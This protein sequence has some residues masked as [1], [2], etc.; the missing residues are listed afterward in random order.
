MAD[1]R[2]QPY[3][4]DPSGDLEKDLPQIITNIDETFEQ[5]INDLTAVNDS[6]GDSSSGASISSVAQG[7]IFYGSATDVVSNLAKDTNATRSL[8]NTGSSNN[9]AWAQ[10]ALAT[11][12]SGN[13]PVANLNSGTSASATTF[14]CGDGTWKT[15][16]NGVWQLIASH[17]LVGGTTSDFTGLVGYTDLRVMLTA[18][19]FG[20]ASLARLRVSIDNGSTFLSAS[21]D[22]IGIQGNGQGNAATEMN[23]YDGAA[24]TTAKY[25]EIWISG[26]N[27]TTPKT[28]RGNFFSSDAM[29]IYQIPTTSDIDAVRVFSTTA[30]TFSGGTIHL[31]G[32]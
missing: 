10:V 13:L 20:T 18:V 1:V 15:P 12:V 9:P 7:D 5:V 28:A 27:L 32:R 21:G 31:F 23:F 3:R 26:T 22:Y 25:G 24:A 14:W 6:I 8:T 11:G 19:T 29:N 4:F 16:T 2:A 17:V 30:N